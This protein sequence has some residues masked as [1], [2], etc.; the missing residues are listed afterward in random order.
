MK[1]DEN[2]TTVLYDARDP[3]ISGI[4]FLAIQTESKQPYV[5]C[6]Y[7]VKNITELPKLGTDMLVLSISEAKQQFNFKKGNIGDLARD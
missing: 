6:T 3:Y 7:T 5:W 4:T 1:M 2:K